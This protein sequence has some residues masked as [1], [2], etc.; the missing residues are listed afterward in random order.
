MLRNYL[1]IAFRSILKNKLTSFINITGLAIAMASA[2]LIFL[3]VSD[4]LVYDQY[5]SKADRTYRI[6]RE[7]FSDDGSVNLRFGN[8]V[9]P[10]GPLLKND[11]G[12][13]ETVARTRN[14]PFVITREE[15]GELK[16]VIAEQGTFFAEPDILK[17]FDFTILSS[18][19]SVLLEKP[20]TLMLSE[21]TAIKFFGDIDVVGKHL[22]VGNRFDMEITGVYKNLP[23]Q[24][25][26]HPDLMLSF[27]TLND[28][29]FYGRK[30]LETQWGN[31][32]FGT[33]IVLEHGGDPKKLEAQLPS[34]LNRHLRVYAGKD[35]WVMPENKDAS[36]TSALRVQK[37][38]DIHL[39]SAMDDELEAGGSLTNVYMISIIGSF[40]ILIACFNFVNLSTA[41]SS[42]RAKEVGLRK[43]VGAFKLQLVYQY[44]GESILIALLGLVFALGFSSMFLPWLN[45]FTQKNISIDLIAHWPLLLILLA[46]SLLIGVLAGIY[47]AFVLSGFKPAIVLK[48]Q[49][50]SFKSRATLRKAL[51]ITQFTISIVLIIA[52]VIIKEQLGYLNTR[53]LGY[54]RDQV[55][56]LP[57]FRELRPNY[58]A[59]HNE[60][61]K[62]SSIGNA[63]L[64]SLVPTNRLVDSYGDAKVT[65]GNNLVDPKVNFR[66]VSVDEDFIDTY[67]I[68]IA[69]GRNFSKSIPTDD[70][71]AFIINETGA[72]A[73]GWKNY[74]DKINSDF[75]YSG[76]NGKLIGIVK[77]FHFESLH[78]PISPTI[79][80][81]RKDNFDFFSVRISSNDMQTSLDYLG[82]VW[83]AY[84][85]K[86]PFDYEFV[87][88][89]YQ[90]L[91]QAEMK[92]N[93]LFTIF[94]SMAVFIACMGLFGLATFNTL[95]RFK[96][97]GIRKVLGAS[98]VNIL[99]LLTSEILLLVIIASV[100]A[101]PLAWYLM[102]QWLIL[103]AYHIEMNLLVYL[104]AAL[105]AVVVALMTISA[106]AIRAAT[107]N[108][109]N[110]LK[111]E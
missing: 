108:P 64:S 100:V 7:F 34:F 77:D 63:A 25:H 26:W 29:T 13:I 92:E 53:P 40:I 103:F 101:C 14:F 39:R 6:T 75:Q 62:N 68:Q 50:G 20:N 102:S 105:F 28:S 5:N 22:R 52:T 70:S 81:I 59:F 104:S 4:E 45:S 24:S 89:N 9:A 47:P 69:A 82:K 37:V 67:G 79:F 33:Y 43:V 46:F 65:E 31:N 87:S 110:T 86:R 76:V 111:Y 55:V 74:A 21:K 94:S 27:S 36:K 56:V 57:F 2:I 35:K 71:L 16:K 91:Y 41:T 15:H 95:Q 3:F 83:K 51:V 30:K 107:T 48:G 10:I 32:Q 93:Q 18:S 61:T 96:E 99:K 98:V 19:D 84:L 80:L 11:F 66:S 60:L 23:I 44:L 12:E 1:L 85:P 88:E 90:H 109:S 106:Q 42:N 17:I 72:N 54:K 49:R 97:I 78:Q 58:D 8:V 38:T 73:L